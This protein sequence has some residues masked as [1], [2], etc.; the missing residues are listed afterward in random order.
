MTQYNFDTGA[1]S[2]TTTDMAWNA[3]N[4]SPSPGCMLKVNGTPF[5]TAE[6]QLTGLSIVVATGDKLSFRYRMKGTPGGEFSQA[7][8]TT[9]GTGGEGGFLGSVQ[10][11]NITLS[12]LGDTGWRYAEG[13]VVDPGGTIDT[14]TMRVG[15]IDD[16]EAFIQF[17]GFDSAFVDD[18]PLPLKLVAGQ[19]GGTISTGNV[20]EIA[21]AY[22]PIVCNL[23]AT[24]AIVAFTDDTGTGR[25]QVVNKSSLALT[26]GASSYSL[27]ASTVPVALFALSSTKAVALYEPGS[28]VILDI[29]GDV[30]TVGT[31][32]ALE[33]GAV[34]IGG[35]RL[36]ATKFFVSY[37]ISTVAR[38]VVASVATS[39]I[40]LNTPANASSNNSEE[41]S[42]ATL[43]DDTTVMMAYH[44]AADTMRLVAL[45][46][47]GV[48]F[49]IADDE[50]I[51]SNV[52]G[53]M[54]TPMVSKLD[55]TRVVVTW[56][57]NAAEFDC[58][59]AI[60]TLSGGALTPGAILTYSTGAASRFYPAVGALS[61]ARIA[62][63]YIYSDTLA[64]KTLSGSSTTLTDNNNEVVPASSGNI[65]S[66]AVMKAI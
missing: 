55:A 6:T 63:A 62:A 50:L 2:W 35:S 42:C 23:S 25:V 10:T 18:S 47:S 38:G 16:G 53:P 12:A 5:K 44:S 26:L 49:S 13:E 17:A 46:I 7:V 19:Y 59:G 45:T 65:P 32:V 31:P 37:V 52:S 57:N 14:L 66:V 3:S 60:V 58:K 24:K 9:N 1:E 51:D 34:F 8:F 15:S 29:A 30:I 36:T 20:I 28:A 41:T 43:V 21:D 48:G 11:G 56:Y 27:G 39:T 40:T 61:D 54:G 22:S 4:G 33:T 64:V